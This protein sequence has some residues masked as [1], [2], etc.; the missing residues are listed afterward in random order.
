MK[1]IN[2]VLG[3]ATGGRWQV[4]LDYC[5]ILQ[6]LGHEVVL[7]AER[8]KITANTRIP[9]GVQLI[10]LRNSGHYDMRATLRCWRLMRRQRPALVLAHCS[11]SVALFKRA[12][13]GRTPVIA[14]SHSNN[15]RRMAAADGFINISSHIRRQIRGFGGRH[16]PAVQ[17]PNMGSFADD[18][19]YQSRPWQKTPRI[20]A[21]GRLDPV[22]GFHIW[23][24]AL[25]LL[26]ARGIAFQAVLAGDGEQRDALAA[27]IAAR[28]LGDRLE[29]RGWTDQPGEFMR[30]VDLLCVPALSDAFGLTPLDAAASATPLVLSTASGH[31]D[32]FSDGISARYATVGDARALADQLA[33]ALADEAAMHRMAAQ[34]FNRVTD[35][36][37]RQRLTERLNDAVQLFSRNLASGSDHRR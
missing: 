15:V 14:I 18:A 19:H 9:D 11:R 29:L 7:V 10:T 20:G 36:Y 5:E 24:D 2:T 4:V 32:M 1:I 6:Q 17:I 27:Q 12:S 33:A 22:K 8:R 35:H 23:V 25:A 16:K 26:K 21:I 13:H 34:A 28:G 31:M 3:D 30:E 37:S